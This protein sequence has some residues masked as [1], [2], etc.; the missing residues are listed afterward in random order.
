MGFICFYKSNEVDGA[1]DK[2]VASC[3]YKFERNG[4]Y[5]CYLSQIV[6]NNNSLI[7]QFSGEH[8]SGYSYENVTKIV[9]EKST[10]FSL[11][12][13]IFH[14]FVNIEELYVTGSNLKV[15]NP[16]KK[17]TKL[18]KVYVSGNQLEK[19]DRDAFKYCPNIDVVDANDNKLEKFYIGSQ[20]RSLE[21]SNNKIEKIEPFTTT[22]TKLSSLSFSFNA[23][24][25]LP[26]GCFTYCLNLK[27]LYLK[28]ANLTHLKRGMFDGLYE[29]RTLYL[30]GNPIEDIECEV[31]YDT[32]KLQVLEIS[33]T[34]MKKFPS[35]VFKSL[36][37]LEEFNFSNNSEI[38]LDDEFF[39]GMR[40]LYQLRY[41]WLN[42]NQIK[43]IDGE[44]FNEYRV[45]GLSLANNL[46][47]EFPEHLPESFLEMDLSN[48]K[49]TV[50]PNGVFEKESCN[51]YYFSLNDNRI[52]DIEEGTFAVCTFMAL[53]LNRNQLKIIKNH[54]FV[55]DYLNFL[56]LSGNEISVIEDEAFF[57]IPDLFE[58]DLSHNKMIYISEKLFVKNTRLREIDLS[59]N[60]IM[61]AGQ[62]SF[63]TPCIVLNL[64]KNVCI[65]HF[66]YIFCG[67]LLHEEL[68]NCN[69]EEVKCSFELTRSRSYQCVVLEMNMKK[70]DK[71]FYG[72]DHIFSLTNSDVGIVVFDKSYAEKIGTEI[73]FSFPNL[74][75][76]VAKKC[77]VTLLD[78]FQ[79]CSKLTEL[80]LD[81]NRIES[82]SNH[83]F[84]QCTGLRV[85]S[86]TDN[87]LKIQKSSQIFHQLLNLQYL[88][89]C[90][91]NLGQ[92]SKNLFENNLKL[93]EICITKN[94]ITEIEAGTFNGLLH[95]DFVSLSENICINENFMIYNGNMEKLLDRLKNCE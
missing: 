53:Q 40:R 55:I 41:I 13:E 12:Q 76:L 85:L 52:S 16:S 61:S 22:C 92:I 23:L 94:N 17:C 67:T 26:I 37:S 20:L 54:Y 57:S 27:F 35:C 47:A 42:G 29:L 18:K 75:L 66:Y 39:N 82:I 43:R 7:V 62:K 19:I 32:D 95:L 45:T 38:N 63:G 73:F 3:W 71:V 25:H 34:K 10:M 83:T 4:I 6:Y 56:E 86:L 31:F 93:K 9:I 84:D 91:N 81:S 72:G 65:D 2:Q 74:E 24:K 59:F 58:I 90:K 33:G 15:I 51:A 48:N 64:E 28:S 14:T 30:N 21:V 5:S 78:V 44:W 88:Y 60:Y 50:I 77:G 87:Q 11:P 89:L 70:E 68:E 49:I 8:F 69:Y 46:L 80:Y 1:I 79:N 36:A